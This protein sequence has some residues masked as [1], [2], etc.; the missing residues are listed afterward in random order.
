MWSY[1]SLSGMQWKVGSSEFRGLIDCEFSFEY[2]NIGY[3]EVNKLSLAIDIGSF[4]C[5]EDFRP[6]FFTVSTYREIYESLE[7]FER[8]MKEF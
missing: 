1:P 3:V 4:S 6:I 5:I 7:W 2:Y 8:L